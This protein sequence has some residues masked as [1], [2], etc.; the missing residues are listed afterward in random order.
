MQAVPTQVG[1]VCSCRPSLVMRGAVSREAGSGFS[2]VGRRSATNIP[3]ENSA[4]NSSQLLRQRQGSPAPS[5]GIRRD[6]ACVPIEHRVRVLLQGAAT[7]SLG[8]VAALRVGGCGGACKERD[9]W[10]DR[11]ERS[12]DAILARVPK[13]YS[14]QSGNCPARAFGVTARASVR[15]NV[16]ELLGFLL[17][18]YV[19]DFCQY[20]V[21][22]SVGPTENGTGIAKSRW[23]SRD[24]RGR[25]RR[26]LFLVV[27]FPVPNF[28]LCGD[29]SISDLCPKK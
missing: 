7:K 25:T 5:A 27:D 3:A 13:G 18:R 17:A 29:I 8:E 21:L 14:A 11:Q 16:C 23:S 26:R 2:Q 28:G 10:S 9:G 20:S 12:L 4:G 24:I 1:A 15:V 6:D 22:L 19:S